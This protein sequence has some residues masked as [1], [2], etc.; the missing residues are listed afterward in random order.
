MVSSEGRLDVRLHPL[1]LINI[2]DHATRVK[3]ERRPGALLGV[4]LGTLE[5]RRL[6]IHNSFEV[7]TQEDQIQAEFFNT[8]TAQ[9]NEIFPKLEFV[10]W[11]T[12]GSEPSPGLQA[13]H[14]RFIELAKHESPLV[15]LLDTEAP[16]TQ[17]QL[18][19]RVY[20]PVSVVGE[21]VAI[22][23]EPIECQVDTLESERIA[24]SHLAKT[25]KE[26]TAGYSSDFTSHTTS[27]AKSVLMLQK[28]VNELLAYV[29]GVKAGTKPKDH[30]VLREL[31]A[32]C[33]ALNTKQPEAL[34]A[35]F[36]ADHDEA[37]LSVYLSALT[38]TVAHTG[39]L[40]DKFT[41][42]QERKSYGRVMYG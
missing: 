14:R 27:V 26:A 8:R 22:K 30:A 37:M 19:V 20:D 25:A 7:V 1:V 41:V 35:K 2:G 24:I 12:C 42:T 15:L 4:L 10:G 23:F 9:Y 16:A 40:L 39:D 29:E 33:H 11:Y 3:C 31:L 18:P 34:A 38:K 28:R 6:S 21:S 36:Q 17:E 13:V 32:V 5:G